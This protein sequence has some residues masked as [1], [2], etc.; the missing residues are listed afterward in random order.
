M[1]SNSD[2]PIFSIVCAGALLAGGS[3]FATA[4]GF[5]ADG[6]ECDDFSPPHVIVGNF[7]GANDAYAADVDG[8]GDVDVVGTAG[9]DGIQGRHMMWWENAVGDGRFWIE[10]TVDNSFEGVSVHA[11]DVDGDGDVDI[12]GASWAADDITWWENTAGDGTLWIEH[13][14]DPDFSLAEDVYAADVDGDGNLD[15]LGAALLSD[16]ITWWRNAA[17]DGTVWIEHTVDGDFDGAFSVY[18]ADVDGDGDVDVLGGAISDHNLIWWENTTGDGTVWIRH[19]VQGSHDA[20]LVH[21]ADVDGDGDVD[22]VGAGTATDMIAWWENTAGDGTL[23]T[24]HT[25]DGAYDGAHGVDAADVDGDGDV[26]V[27][28]AATEANDLT[29]WENTA[30]DGTV[31]TEHTLDDHFSA[32]KSVFAADIDGD[33]DIDVLGVAKGQQ[34]IT[35]FENLGCNCPADLNDNGLVGSGDLVFLLG[36]WGKNP[37]H[38]AD[39]NGDGAVN[40]IDLIELLGNWGPC[41]K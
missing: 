26:D 12:L 3:A 31:W 35:W 29:W 1:R 13:P 5:N 36:A 17:G 10:H 7:N 41:P 6:G 37:D 24:R 23:W 25:I 40:A 9:D 8:D 4:G 27:L 33:A 20:G 18:A 15:I 28:G 2:S 39:L 32:A 38:P 19:A 14:V 30:G 11:A 22:V 21:A 34:D 16:D